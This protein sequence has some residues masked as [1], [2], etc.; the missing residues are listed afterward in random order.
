[1]VKMSKA[2][3]SKAGKALSKNGTSAAGKKLAHC[4]W[5][6]KK[7]KPAA[8]KTTA[9]KKPAAKK[10]AAKKSPAKKKATKAPSKK[11]EKKP[12]RV[13]NVPK[14]VDAMPWFKK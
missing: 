1:M 4:R 14:S 9:K 6:T 11:E 7:K 5:G 2:E 12:G 3:C 8:K 13:I 10:A